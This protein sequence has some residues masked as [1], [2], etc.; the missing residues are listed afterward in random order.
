MDHETVTCLTGRVLRHNSLAGV[1]KTLLHTSTDLEQT[2]SKV[3]GIKDVDVL[4]LWS[5]AVERHNELFGERPIDE[6]DVKGM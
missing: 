5:K 2:L 4:S 3:F 1:R 6:I